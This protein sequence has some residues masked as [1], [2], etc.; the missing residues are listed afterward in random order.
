MFSDMLK[1][2]VQV[3]RLSLPKHRDELLTQFICLFH[4]VTRLTDI[5]KSVLLRWRQRLMLFDKQK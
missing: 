5:F 1:P 4:F 3:L 2:P